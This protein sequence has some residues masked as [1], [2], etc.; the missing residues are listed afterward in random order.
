M[1]NQAYIFDD[2]CVADAA[3]GQW[4]VV[5]GGQE[6]HSDPLLRLHVKLPA[7]EDARYIIGVTQHSVAASGDTVMVRRAGITKVR[8]GTANVVFGMPLR[9][10]DI[11]GNAAEQVDEWASGDGVLGYAEEKSNASG[12][13]I[14]CWLAIRELLGGDE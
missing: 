4:K 11:R 9:I 1:G 14:E 10:H 12:D 7:A 3:L 2:S 8:A 5:V 13:I 6:R